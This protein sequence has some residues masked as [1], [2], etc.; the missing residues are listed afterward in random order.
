MIRRPIAK[1]WLRPYLKRQ[2]IFS[3]VVS[4]AVGII[5]A[6]ESCSRSSNHDSLFSPRFLVVR[7]FLQKGHNLSLID[8]G[9]Q[10]VP[11]SKSVPLGAL[12]DQDLHWAKGATL[13]RGL[14]KGSLITIDD[15]HLPARLTGLGK[16]IP[17][18]MRAYSIVENPALSLVEGDRVDI[19]S[20]PKN[21]QQQPRLVVEGARVVQPRT[22]QRS[23][24]VAVAVQDVANLEKANQTGKLRI[25]LRNP[26]DEP[27]G[28]LHFKSR[29]KKVRKQTLEIVE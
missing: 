28:Q 21:P 2:W 16:A 8:L 11:N 4:I 24:L 10:R 22:D 20:I 27:T 23:T 12:T 1:K 7:R 26:L 18:G 19:L 14:E 6:M 3:A 9:V 17:R 29:M 25:V 13:R 5:A 15:I